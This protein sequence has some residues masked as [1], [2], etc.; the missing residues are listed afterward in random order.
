MLMMN[1]MKSKDLKKEQRNN[2]S[3]IISLLKLCPSIM[4]ESFILTGKIETVCG[5]SNWMQIQFQK[6]KR[7]KYDTGKIHPHTI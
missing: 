2:D 5:L 1:F 4:S 6:I 3:Q 7:H